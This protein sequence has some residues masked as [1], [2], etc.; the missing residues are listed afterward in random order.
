MNKS[1]LYLFS[2]VITLSLVG[3]LPSKTE[4]KQANNGLLSTA[5]SPTT[6]GKHALLIGIENYR[7]VARLNG[8]INDV[9]LMKGLL[10]ERF[11]FQQDDFIILLDEKATH[12]GIEQAFTA[13]IKRVNPGDFVYIHYSGHGSQTADLNGDEPRDQKDETW[14]S[15]GTREP[16]QENE[17]DNYDVLDD[18]I[19]AWLAAIYAKTNQVIFV[20]DSCHSGTVARGKAPISRGLK[21]DK[22]SHPLGRK[23]YTKL[24]KYHGVHIGSARDHELATE[25]LGEDGKHYGLFT[26]HWAKA[27]QSA[28]KEETWQQVFKRAYT[29]VVAVRGDAQMPQLE[30]ERHRQVFGGQITPPVATVSI[31][32]VD[33]KSVTIAAGGVAGVTVGSI[34]RLH[35]PQ[36]PD[37]ES[38]PHFKITQVGTFESEGKTTVGAF[39]VGDLVVEESH[40][41][42][43]APIKVYLSA[44]YPNKQDKQLL[45]TIRAAFQPGAD[46]TQPLPGYELTDDPSHTDLRLHLLRPKRENGQPIQASAEDAL[47][48]SFEDQPPE[49]W[50]LSQGQRLLHNNLQMPFDNPTKGVALLQDNLNKLARVRETKALENRHGGTLPV[51]VQTTVYSPANS[52]K[53]GT[54]C[55]E[56]PSLG[57]HCKTGQYSWSEMEQ[58]L[59]NKNDV[60]TFTLHNE[61]KQDYYSYLINISSDGGIYAIFPHPEEGREYARIKAGKKLV[62]ENV[63]LLLDSAG[64]QTLKL[65]ATTQ[66]MDV[67]LLEQERFKGRNQS[68]LN[69]LEL[70]LTNAVHGQR[71][72]TRVPKNY[73]WVTGQVTFDVSTAD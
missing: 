20:S 6:S 58:R 11:G 38:L 10:R 25:T 56:L 70:L 13:L 30:G 2:A 37:P 71:G 54:E 26:W 66:A 23:A 50:I 41:Y 57:K 18:E 36:H 12:T 63:M 17:I 24:D 7:N 33:G 35:K 9:N 29:P 1:T 68:T 27:L 72:V 43:F 22:R 73:E 39:K 8:A 61:S 60:L 64:E 48:K 5:K 49:L 52:S 51:T 59:L 47:P 62:L 55:R 42:H 45:Q 4:P 67:S 44:D 21:R 69:P 34:Y 16:Q 28:Q 3:C 31:N 15:F 32:H 65:F 46:G 53:G 14:V 40:A 19:N